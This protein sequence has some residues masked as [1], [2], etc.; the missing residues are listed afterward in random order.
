MNA[1]VA[2][3]VLAGHLRNHHVADGG[4]IG[5]M[6]NMS[7]EVTGTYFSDALQYGRRGGRGM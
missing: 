3:R 2:G 1:A 7:T 5:M 6:S 4:C